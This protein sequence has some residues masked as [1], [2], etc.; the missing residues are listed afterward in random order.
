MN[1]KDELVKYQR[2]RAEQDAINQACKFHPTSKSELLKLVREP[3][4]NLGEIDTSKITDMS[5]L[6]Y[7]C[8]R[9][10]FSGIEKWDTSNVT[11]MSRMFSCSP[12]FYEN[13]EVAP[14]EISENLHT[15]L[16]H[17]NVS[18]V[19]NMEEMFN[20][21]NLTGEGIYF[22][23]SSCKNFEHMFANSQVKQNVDLDF[24]ACDD[25]NAISGMFENSPN[26]QVHNLPLT[27]IKEKF[28]EL[29][30]NELSFRTGFGVRRAFDL[31]AQ[32]N[33]LPNNPKY[34]APNVEACNIF[35]QALAKVKPTLEKWVKE[36]FGEKGFVTL[37][38]HEPAYVDHVKLDYDRNFLDSY[39][40]FDYDV[41]EGSMVS[42]GKIYDLTDT[43]EEVMNN[44]IQLMVSNNQEYQ[45]EIKISDN[46]IPAYITA[47]ALEWDEKLYFGDDGDDEYIYDNEC[48]NGDF[49]IG[50]KPDC[51]WSLDPSV[52]D[53]HN[54]RG[55]EEYK[56]NFDGRMECLSNYA[57]E[58]PE[59]IGEYL[60]EYG[61]PA[62]VHNIEVVNNYI[63]ENDAEIF[64][65]FVERLDV[66]TI[67]EETTSVFKEDQY[68]DLAYRIALVTYKG[69][70]WFA[71]PVLQEENDLFI[72]AKITEDDRKLAVEI[73]ETAK[74]NIYKRVLN[75]QVDQIVC[76]LEDQ[77]EL[78]DENS[79][80]ED[81]KQQE[82]KKQG[83]R[84]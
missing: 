13:N 20:R 15:Q 46:K 37:L 40:L 29:E 9:E 67:W 27:S 76:D 42:L 58:H 24:N 57:N 1:R 6:F 18:K 59:L 54:R 39:E 41:K 35:A 34:T 12:T 56:L 52:C 55:Q 81:L 4:I 65:H 2:S 30:F 68:Q 8:K 48:A 83:R 7:D 53:G 45:P 32:E 25:L 3:K 14:L 50:A 21:S 26:I 79:Q 60:K 61:A 77:L 84:R 23:S 16:S 5:G 44:Y 31:E 17:W 28:G 43:E 10:D 78:T 49:F 82:V 62:T 47:E 11:D 73:L 19:E 38:D 72:P 64:D 51:T 22:N 33:K 36:N 74:E 75:L 66:E 63:K 70:D 69:K 80:Q 71:C